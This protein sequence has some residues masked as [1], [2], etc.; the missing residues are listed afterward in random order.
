MVVV[1]LTG[2][3][4]VGKTTL[5]RKVAEAL[6]DLRV[7]VGGFVTEEIRSLQGQREGFRVCDLT[8]GEEAPLATKGS[9]GKGP[10]VGRYRVCLQEFESVA[11]KAMREGADV[12]EGV[13]VIDEI[14]EGKKHSLQPLSFIPGKME[15]LSGKFCHLLPSCLD[16]KRGVLCTAPIKGSLPIVKMVKE[17]PDSIV[18]EVRLSSHSMARMRCTLVQVTR[19]NRDELLEKI[20][21]LLNGYEK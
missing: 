18:I 10:F 13:L 3:P 4:G 19:A 1:V 5:C 20:V 21:E 11:L 7:P 8:S 17:R 9:S 15:S 12:R 6:L 16:G 2:S 14:G